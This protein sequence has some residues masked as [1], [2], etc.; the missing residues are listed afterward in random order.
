MYDREL[1]RM[2]NGRGTITAPKKSSSKVEKACRTAAHP[3]LNICGELNFLILS[4]HCYDPTMFKEQYCN[5]W[6]IFGNKRLKRIPYTA[7]R[8][9]VWKIIILLSS[10][11]K[12]VAKRTNNRPFLENVSCSL[13]LPYAISSSLSFSTTNFC[14]FSLP[15]LLVIFI[16]LHIQEMGGVM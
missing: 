12:Q 10:V 8:S 3:T 9:F 15:F 16:S 11:R 4:A 2:A 7:W 13:L 14:N 5:D 1:I 6:L